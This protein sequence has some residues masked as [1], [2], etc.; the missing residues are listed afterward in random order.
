MREGREA[1]TK[2]GTNERTKERTKGTNERTK[3]ERKE[4]RKEGKNVPPPPRSVDV[5]VVEMRNETCGVPSRGS[6]Q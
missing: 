4:G 1:G 2:D 5:D 3:G 6:V